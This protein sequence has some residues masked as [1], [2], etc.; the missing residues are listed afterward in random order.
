MRGVIPAIGP[1]EISR[2]CSSPWC[3]G[4]YGFGSLSLLS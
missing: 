3:D 2:I 4:A 1:K